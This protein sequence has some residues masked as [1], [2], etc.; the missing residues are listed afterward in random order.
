MNAS[1]APPALK[2]DRLAALS[3]GSLRE[4]VAQNIS[5]TMVKRKQ[6][7]D[8]KARRPGTEGGRRRRPTGRRDGPDGW[9]GFIYGH[10]AVLAALTNPRRRPK[11]L[12]TTKN[13]LK[14]LEQAGVRPG[15]SPQIASFEEI[16]ALLPPGAVHQ[17]IALETE[18]LP[19][20]DLTAACAEAR[21]VVALDQVTDPHNVGA[22]LRSAAVFGASAL[23]MTERHSPPQTGALAKAASGALESVHL[24]RVTNLARTL[25][26]L[27]ELGFQIVGLDGEAETTLSDL[28]LSGPVAIVLG[29]EGQGLRRLTRERCDWLARIPSVGRLA[30][31]N[32]SNA[33]AVALYEL[34]RAPSSG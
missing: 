28:S 8:R 5:G 12:L 33:A 1:A 32:V 31:L 30:S 2:P 22:I 18:P 21:C 15:I 23:I 7:P 3:K 25:A 4:P 9:D 16:A 13:A 26:T 6:T 11:R 14:Q 27:K 19:E 34:T 20:P 17:G 10:H 24:V 29:A